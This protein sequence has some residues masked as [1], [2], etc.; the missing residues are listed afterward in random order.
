MQEVA[1][2]ILNESRARPQKRQKIVQLH[3][4]DIKLLI[5]TW[6]TLVVA[7]KVNPKVQ[8]NKMQQIN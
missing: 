6:K 5:N 2:S 4:Q 1:S 7:Q 8:I 3:H